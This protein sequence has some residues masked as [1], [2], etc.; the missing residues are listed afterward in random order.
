[1][2]RARDTG[3]IFA[4][5]GSLNISTSVNLGDNEKAYFGASND[6]QIYH[7]GTHSYISDQGSGNLYLQSASY[8]VLETANGSENYLVAQENGPVTLYYDNTAKLATTSGGIDVNG[9]VTADAATL[10]GTSPVL[11]YSDTDNSITAQIGSGTSDFNI[12]TTSAHNLDIRTNNTR[13][14]V[15]ES[16]G[17]ISFYADNGTTQGLFWDASTQRLGLGSTSPQSAVDID[18][19]GDVAVRYANSGTFKGYVGVATSAGNLMSGSATDELIVRSTDGIAFAANNARAM[20]IISA[21][22]VGIAD[23][24]PQDTLHVGGTGTTGIKIGTQGSTGRARIFVDSGNDYALTVDTQN[25]SDALVIN[26][27]SGN[28]GINTSTPASLLEIKASALNRANGIAL[29]GSGANDILYMYP[30]ADNVATIEHLIDGSTST[31]GNIAINPQGGNVGIGTSTPSQPLTISTSGANGLYLLRDGNT[32]A[33][34]AR[35]YLDSSNT[36]WAIMVEDGELSFRSAPN[37]GSSSGT[38]RVAFTVNGI[39]SSAVAGNTTVSSPNLF[40]SG[41]NNFQKSTS[42]RRYKTEITDAAHG[43]A[44]VLN[45]RSVTYKGVNDGET[46]F[47]GLIAEEVHDAGLT[48]FVNYSEDENG[49]N[50][51]EGVHYGHM[52]SLAFKAIQELK[53]E[54]D[55]EKVKTATLETQRADLEAR[56]TALENA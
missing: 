20:T 49:N 17:D 3:S 14:M 36:P 27:T 38:E 2:T 54:L 43:L 55:A 7:D 9:S 32:A 12:A 34:S 24:S 31:G 15:V 6:L 1:M 42:S 4:S 44:D 33:N 47:G 37:P 21:G 29:R 46:V 10:S 52:V 13:R 48:E 39:N 45:L 51:P 19:T 41:G 30:S 11:S 35:I 25:V 26:R 22:N 28:V 8:L 18:G 56:L 50:V 16:D 23:A 53:A 40:I 5:D